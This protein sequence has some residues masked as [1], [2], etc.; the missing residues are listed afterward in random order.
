MV[1]PREG[2]R[3]APQ[4][5]TRQIYGPDTAPSS[6]HVTSLEEQIGFLAHTLFID[7][8]TANWF[9]V[10]NAGRWIPPYTI[11][12]I[13]PLPGGTQVMDVKPIAPP[14]F[15]NLTPC[16]EVSDQ[17]AE[18]ALVTYTAAIHPPVSGFDIGELTNTAKNVFQGTMVETETPNTITTKPPRPR[19][20]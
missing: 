19:R 14:A 3:N 20:T 18:Y 4:T 2:Q 7:N 9:F 13:I 1:Q 16:V 5:I 10:A 11:G 8:A 15:V 17:A 12:W 6:T